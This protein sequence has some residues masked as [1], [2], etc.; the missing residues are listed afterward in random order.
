L[1][2]TTNG[3]RLWIIWGT[4]R[5]ENAIT[6]AAR[7]RLG[8]ALSGRPNHCAWSSRTPMERSLAEQPA[9]DLQPAV[10]AVLAVPERAAQRAVPALERG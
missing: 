6:D 4:V 9:D 1:A 7:N 8:V 5:T 2:A 3:A 10:H